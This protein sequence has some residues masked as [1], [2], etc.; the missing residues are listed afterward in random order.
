M[1]HVP[2]DKEQEEAKR[3]IMECADLFDAAVV[4]WQKA[5]EASP[6]S[7]ALKVGIHIAKLTLPEMG[8]ETRTFAKHF[9]D[10]DDEQI[11]TAGDA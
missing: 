2:T 11:K 1:T 7:N 4:L 3:Y 9:S 5:C 6:N 10:A 8:R